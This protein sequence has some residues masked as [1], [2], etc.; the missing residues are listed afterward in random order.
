MMTGRGLGLWAIAV[1]AALACCWAGAA[2]A[3]QFQ[4]MT[5]FQPPNAFGLGWGDYDGDG[6]PDLFVGGFDQGTDFPQ[7]GPVL[8]RNN[9]D[10]T[11]TDVSESLGL[12]PDPIE[13]DGIAW[14]DYDNDGDLDVLVGSGAGYPM[15]YRRDAD[16]FVEFGQES[17]FHVTFSAG[18]GTNWCDYDG[19]SLLDAF[20]SNI[21]GPGY[22]LHNNGNGTFTD[23]SAAAG[24]AG[25]ALNDQAQSASWGDFDN[26]GW[27]DLVL[28]R[29]VKPTKLYRNNGDGTFTDVSASSGMSA[30]ADAYS[31]VWGDYDND[32]WLDCYVTSGNY[33][34]PQLR[35]DALFHNNGDG[36]FTDVATTVGM[37]TDFANGIGAAWADYDNDGYLDLFVSN[38]GQ[39]AFLYHNDGDGTFTNVAATSGAAGDSYANAVAWA[40][41]DLDGRL[42]LIEAVYDE[43]SRVFHNAGPAGN[44][45]RVQAL[46]SGSGDATGTDPVRDAIGARVDVNLDSDDSFAPGRTLTRMIDGGSGFCAQNEQIAHFGLGFG[47]LVNPVVA[48]R[49]RFPDGSVVVHRS[50]PGN[51]HIVIRD[52]P[53]DREEIFDDVP[54]DYWAYPAVA[55]ALEAGIVQ[56]YWDDT[57]RPAG[58]VDRASMAVYIARAVTGGDEAVPDPSGDTPTFT[59]VGADHWAYRYIEYAASPAANVVQG[60]PGGN[61]QPDG[62]VNRG[63]MAVYI[64]R[65]MVTPSG[66]AGV[67]DPPAGDPTFSDVTAT[68][69]WSWC[70]NHVEYLAA[71]GIVQGY[72]DGTYHPATIVTRDQMA[73]YIQRA[74]DLPL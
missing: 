33:T 58:Q 2:G 10:L 28:A 21:F 65:A 11:F 51:Q 70:Y 35:A 31:A 17:G 36:T 18:R 57:Y 45:L 8:Y 5:S 56:G 3:A 44:C 39:N 20:C 9:G 26:D 50:V 71:E 38:L 48:V 49:V 52:V 64:A 15:L 27:P 13:Q 59:D 47:D 29:M 4:E 16:Q 54:L 23:V 43:P 55:A 24:M 46:T 14:G 60:Y 62:L 67:P 19:D 42:D 66:D 41:I 68:G 40:D 74:F 30:Y 37:A 7:H 25:D 72:P 73:V 63:Q 22:L 32:G 69:D 34:E 61:Y 1:A 53:A 6:Y 12:A